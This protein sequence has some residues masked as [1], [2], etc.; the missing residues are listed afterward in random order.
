MQDKSTPWVAADD[1]SKSL[2][3]QYECKICMSRQLETVFL[4]CG[5]CMSCRGCASSLVHC[6][7][8]I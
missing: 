8:W 2:A 3:R 4:P 1:A 6:P 7:V 5:H